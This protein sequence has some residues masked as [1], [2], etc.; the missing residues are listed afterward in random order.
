MRHV[1]PLCA[2]IVCGV[3]VLSGWSL[4]S[5]PEQPSTR[6]ADTRPEELNVLDRYVGIW[7]SKTVVNNSIQAPITRNDKVK[8]HWTL[9]RQFIEARR[10]KPDGSTVSLEMASYNEET[11]EYLAWV[12]E[13]AGEVHAIRG[14]W[15]EAEKMMTW[16][17]TKGPLKIILRDHF[18]EDGSIET[19]AVA[20]DHS[21]KH[22][23]SWNSISTREK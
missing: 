11:G 3:L 14:R 21:G 12:F 13:T 9:G 4:A 17:G 15:N 16:Q 7:Q 1:L 23:V 5:R 20:D 18:R 2:G 22:V 8:V 19:S 6:P 10:V